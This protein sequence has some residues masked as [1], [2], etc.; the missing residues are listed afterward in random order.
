L[1]RLQAELDLE[2]SVVILAEHYSQ[3]LQKV[4]SERIV[5]S[6][7]EHRRLLCERLEALETLERW[8][9]RLGDVKPESGGVFFA[10]ERFH[11]NHRM[12]YPGD[13]DWSAG[14]EARLESLGAICCLL[15]VSAARV[16]ERLALRLRRSG[17]PHDA[18]QIEQATRD[19]LAQQERY[20][21]E[22]K[23]SSLATQIL[24]TDDMDW[25]RCARA[26]LATAPPGSW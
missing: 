17:K 20:L 24:D 14:I 15:T 23:H 3:A 1:K 4:G 10:L 12:S 2:R 25:N 6:L 13:G 21:A 19:F 8:G 18:S 11:L 5:L 7:E 9:R 16:P 26:I 22:A